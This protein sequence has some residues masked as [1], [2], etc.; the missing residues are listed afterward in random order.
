M[1]DFN[2]EPGK[3]YVETYTLED[4]LM[5]AIRL[6]SMGY[7]LCLENKYFCFNIGGNYT[8]YFDAPADEGEGEPLTDAQLEAVRSANAD[9]Q[10]IEMDNSLLQDVQNTGTSEKIEQAPSEDTS[11]PTDVNTAVT[12]PAE[13]VIFDAPRRGRPPRNRT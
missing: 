10:T 13:S 3:A 7:K 2:R 5:A 4:L 6:G 9:L 11:T 8:A 1:I 12:P